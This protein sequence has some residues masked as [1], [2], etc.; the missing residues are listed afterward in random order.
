MMQMEV[1]IPGI[2]SHKRLHD[3][4]DRVAAGRD[5]EMKMICHETVCVQFKWVSFLDAL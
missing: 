4:P 2:L 3:K 5:L 1:E